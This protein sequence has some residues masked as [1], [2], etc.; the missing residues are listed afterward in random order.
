MVWR[1]LETKDRWKYKLNVKEK[2]GGEY[3]GEE[4]GEGGLCRLDDITSISRLP[5]SVEAKRQQ[6][7]LTLTNQCT[8]TPKT[9][10][11]LS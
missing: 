3:T 1:K 5:L 9:H 6:T 7:S 10:K 8:H 11:E 2:K 4:E